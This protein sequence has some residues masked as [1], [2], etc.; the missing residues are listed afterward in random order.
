[1]DNGSQFIPN[2]HGRAGSWQGAHDTTP[3]VTMFP[4]DGTFSMS[5]T[6][7][8]CRLL[9]VRVYGGPF[10]IW[11][12]LFS[13]GLGAPYNASAYK[14][15]SFWAKVGPSSSTG[16]RLTFPDKDTDPAGGICST[17]PGAP[18]N[19]C[20]DHWGMPLSPL[21]SQSWT[22]V[23]VRFTSLSQGGWGNLVSQFDPSTVYGIQW[24]ILAGAT[25]D[26][27]VDDLAFLTQ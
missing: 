27:W 19:G 6:N 22:K 8:P 1:M 12:A 25:F 20:F 11:G 5:N 9:A 17:A 10:T 13:V 23:T 26:I 2:I 16:V 21:L 4:P 7:D 3:N 24:E 15:V 18:P 14:G